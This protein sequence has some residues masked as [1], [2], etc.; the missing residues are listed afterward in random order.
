[1]PNH[2]QQTQHFRLQ[3]SDFRLQTSAFRFQVSPKRQA[4]VPNRLLLDVRAFDPHRP[5]LHGMPVAEKVVV[6]RRLRM[7]R[8][9]DR[10]EEAAVVGR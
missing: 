10:V 7:P 6:V 1:M 3:T 5:M 4:D 2:I 8:L 9:P